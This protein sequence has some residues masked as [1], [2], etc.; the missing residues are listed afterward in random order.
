MY[1]Q[2]MDQLGTYS[3]RLSM[4]RF[5]QAMFENVSYQTVSRVNFSLSFLFLSLIHF[6]LIECYDACSK[7]SVLVK[8]REAFIN[9]ANFF[10]CKLYY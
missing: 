4:R 1:S 8:R 10:V 5:I 7:G 9:L 6:H 2:M 3:F